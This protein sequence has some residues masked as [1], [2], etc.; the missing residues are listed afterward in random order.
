MNTHDL[1][2]NLYTDL[3]NQTKIIIKVKHD[4]LQ[5]LKKLHMED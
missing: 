2:Y 3:N 5:D 1:Q 4:T